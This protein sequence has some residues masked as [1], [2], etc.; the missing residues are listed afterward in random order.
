MSQAMIRI[1][2]VVAPL[3]ISAALFFLPFA[4]VLRFFPDTPAPV[5]LECSEWEVVQ[6]WNVDGGYYMEASRTCLY[7]QPTEETP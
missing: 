3:T 2:W 4:V 1:G 5:T 7:I 6:T